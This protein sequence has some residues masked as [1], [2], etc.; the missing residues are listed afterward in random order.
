MWECSPR[1]SCRRSSRPQQSKM[2]TLFIFQSLL[3]LA[4]TWNGPRAFVNANCGVQ[5]LLRTS[6]GTWEFVDKKT[7]WWKSDE[8]SFVFLYSYGD[9]PHWAVKHRLGPCSPSVHHTLE[10]GFGIEK[11]F[12]IEK[13]VFF[14]EVPRWIP[15]EVDVIVRCELQPNCVNSEKVKVNNLYLSD[16]CILHR[17]GKDGDVEVDRNWSRFN[18]PGAQLTR[19]E[20]W[21]LPRVD[22]DCVWE[23]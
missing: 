5:S 7:Q 21:D 16:C 12:N 2:E 8:M 20:G 15:S 14:L 11:A 18:T 19:I 10:G 3:F 1:L 23:I 4:D 17:E 13:T 6:V 22:Y 9:L